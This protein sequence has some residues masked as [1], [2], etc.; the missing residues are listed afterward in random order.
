MIR[1][2]LTAALALVVLLAPV[3]PATALPQDERPNAPTQVVNVNSATAAQF[4]ALPGIGPSM[5]QRIV[6][7]REKNG[8][9][10]KLEDL[11]NVQG[12]GEKSFLKLRPYLSVGAQ[13]DARASKD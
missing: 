2:L 7:Y 5:A 11:M 9:F 4:E 8:P 3:V 10:K 1:S 6:S 12:I 13:A